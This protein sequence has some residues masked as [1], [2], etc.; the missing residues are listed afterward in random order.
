MQDF[1]TEIEKN[2]IGQERHAHIRIWYRGQPT[3]NLPLIPGV[4]RGSFPAKSEKERLD[5]ERHLTQE[6]RAQSSG[7]RAGRDTMAEIYFLQQHYRMPTRLLDWTTNPLA[8]LYFAVNADPELDGELFVMDAYRLAN[9]QKAKDFLGIGTQRNQ[10]FLEGLKTIFYWKDPRQLPTFIM[11]L[12]P[13][14]IDM[15][16]TAQ[17]SCFTFHV[18]SRS[19]LSPDENDTLKSFRIPAAS[20]EK[21]KKELFS[22]GVDD[23]TIY[24]DLES[25][26]RR[27]RST[28][29]IG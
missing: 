12:R 15:R 26:S 3:M 23:F 6:F 2:P 19:I 16:I 20:K 24:G 29:F 21:V 7:L 4:Y 13:D 17:N 9:Q 28:H 5:L 25:L 8:G 11:P 10:I 14:F 22:F 27:L 1:L 18:P